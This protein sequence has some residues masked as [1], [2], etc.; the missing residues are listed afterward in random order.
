MGAEQGVQAS[1]PSE[2]G[3]NRPCGPIA[4]FGS[5]LPGVSKTVVVKSEDG[6]GG[7]DNVTFRLTYEGHLLGS[8]RGDPRTKH[9]HE[10]RRVFHGQ[11]ARFW[12]NSAFL[13]RAKLPNGISLADRLANNY[14][15]CGYR[16]V[17]L[18]KEGMLCDIHVLFL[19]SDAPGTLVQ[20]GDIDNRI[21][22]LLDALRMPVMT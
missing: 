21:K 1:A 11:L 3:R 22:T 6:H 13:S 20:S 4:P 19:R 17:P 7:V 8:A 16:W 2:G 14:T 10:I 5:F 12:R 18:V 9:K 15:R